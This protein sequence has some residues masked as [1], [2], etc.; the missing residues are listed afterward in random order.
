MAFAASVFMRSVNVRFGRVKHGPAPGSAVG[1]SSRNA[2]SAE[3]IQ[4]V[5]ILYDFSFEAVRGN[6][7][8]AVEGDLGNN[9]NDV[10]CHLF[11]DGSFFQDA[12]G[13]PVVISRKEL[14]VIGVVEESGESH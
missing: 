14:R 12:A 9:R 13:I 11:G 7:V 5:G 6:A 4:A 10:R 3:G 8:R 1:K 2:D